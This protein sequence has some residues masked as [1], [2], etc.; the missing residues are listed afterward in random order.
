MKIKLLKF[1]N[2]V[3]AIDNDSEIG[4]CEFI[5]DNEVINIIHTYVDKNYRGEG[6]AQQLVDCVIQ[7]AK[8]NNKKVIADCA[9]AKKMLLKRM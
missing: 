8:M 6:I 5:V 2:R 4:E 7:E 1:E 9:Y 3:I